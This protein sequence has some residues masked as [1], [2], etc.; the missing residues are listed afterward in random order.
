MISVRVHRQPILEK[1]LRGRIV[2]TKKPVE[3]KE[4]LAELIKGHGI[5]V[6][7][8]FNDARLFTKS[9]GVGRGKMRD[10]VIDQADLVLL[11]AAAK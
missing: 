11:H 2:R 8:P 9:T 1:P 3:T 10:W 7:F 6:H 5:Y 4:Y